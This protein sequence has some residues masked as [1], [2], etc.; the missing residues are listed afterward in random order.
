MANLAQIALENMPSDLVPDIASTGSEQER[1]SDPSATSTDPSTPEAWHLSNQI[2]DPPT[3]VDINKIDWNL[4]SSLTD[5]LGV[6][7]G[8]SAKSP[9][10]Q[11]PPKVIVLTGVSG[12]LGHHLRDYLLQNTS[13][14]KVIC[15]AVRHLARRLQT[16]ELPQ[17]S[18]VSYYEGDLSQP[19]LGLSEADARAIFGGADAVIHNGADTSHL[20]FFPAVQLANVG[21]TR[22]LVRLALPRRIPFHYVSSVGAGLFQ[23]TDILHPV[24]AADSSPPDD[25]SHGYMAS[26]WTCERFLE[27]VNE[28]YGLDVWIHRPSTIVREGEDAEGAKAQL[29]WVNALLQYIRIMKVAPKV[30]HIRGALDLVYV[31]SVCAELVR[32]VLGGPRP[33]GAVSYVHE[34][35]DVLL[36]LDRLHNI[37]GTVGEVIPMAEWVEKA[38]ASGLHPGVGALI[39]AMDT[40]GTP[41][42]PRLQK[43]SI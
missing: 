39:E 34:V 17:S 36:P 9:Q 6:V 25:G 20:K 26:K 28:R 37:G 23:V 38:V 33:D 35:G 43:G 12:L 16:K 2:T 5:D 10:V 22:Q 29:D 41:D 21:S 27:R 19:R 4:E 31:Q 32:H 15:I 42:Y 3:P 1:I 24:S 8:T 11:F 13:A 14:D 40:A 30:Q 7:A 18:R